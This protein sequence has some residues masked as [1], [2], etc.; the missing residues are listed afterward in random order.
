MAPHVMTEQSTAYFLVAHGS[1]APHSAKSLQ[2]LATLFCQTQP[3]KIMRVGTGALE[4]Q[5]RPL[6]QQ[7]IEFCRSLPPTT[8]LV[9]ILPVFLLPGTHVLEDIPEAIHA[10]QQELRS[11]PQAPH[12]DLR[13]HLGSHPNIGQVIQENLIPESQDDTGKSDAW[14]LMGHGSRRAS[15]NHTIQALAQQL[16]MH[17]AFW[18]SHPSLEDKI[19]ELQ[20]QGIQSIGV[21]PYF[22]FTGKITK[23]ISEQAHQLESKLDP[24][25]IFVSPPLEPRPTLA[26]FL[27]DLC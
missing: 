19:R 27:L 9:K 15:G 17:A 10:A 26:K 1:R 6:S 8:T 11:Q 16:Q 22:L 23:T 14:I 12:L 5:D 7:I 13:S 4:F 2:T 20:A 21:M 3:H 25:R 18:V 24:L